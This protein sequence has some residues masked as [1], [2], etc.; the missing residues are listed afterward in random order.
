MPVAVG[1][2]LRIFAF[3]IDSI[4]NGASN[5]TCQPFR[6]AAEPARTV[7]DPWKPVFQRLVT[8]KSAVGVTVGLAGA[9][10]ERDGVATAGDEGVVVGA[11]GSGVTGTVSLSRI[12]ATA[13]ARPST[14][15]TGRESRSEN[16]SV[17]SA[18][19]SPRT[20]TATCRVTVPAGNETVP[21]RR[22]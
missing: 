3:Q 1:V 9:A 7:H 16:V 8:A 6:A 10:V 17:G 5:E 20:V 12:V 4:A 2:R 14:P 11:T 22:T 21:V 19:R 18:S 15:R 13:A